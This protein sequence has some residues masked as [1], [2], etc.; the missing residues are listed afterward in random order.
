MEKIDIFP[1]LEEI[2]C[3]SLTE[4]P[5]VEYQW[6]RLSRFAVAAVLYLLIG[7]VQWGVV[8]FGVE[9]LIYKPFHNF[10]DLCSISN[11]SVLALTRSQFGYYIHGRSVHGH[12]DTNMSEMNEMLQR[13]RVR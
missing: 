2:Q 4:T 12:A 7:V 5:P 3:N 13:E 10:I 9:T 11:I 8:S 1:H 6:T